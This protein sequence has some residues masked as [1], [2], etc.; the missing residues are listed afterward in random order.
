MTIGDG[1]AAFIDTNV[2]VYASVVEAPLHL[3]ALG[4]IQRREQAGVELWL[5]RQVLREYLA[6]LS[7]PQTYTAPV[8]ASVLISQIQAFEKRFRIAED[9][10]QVTTRLLDLMEQVSIGGKQVHDA[11]IV[12]TMQ[13]YSINHL[14][15]HNTAD[16][17]RFADVIT[18]IPLLVNS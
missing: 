14:L 5:S 17:A 2:L 10:P 1:E 18:I 12:A 16:F 9:G 8:S 3:V 11:N 6:V 13:A 4:E 7:R 15:T